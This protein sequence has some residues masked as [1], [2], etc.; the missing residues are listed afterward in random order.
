MQ[1]PDLLG[2]VG[3]QIDSHGSYPA[4]QIN[5]VGLE[6]RGVSCLTPLNQRSCTRLRKKNSLALLDMDKMVNVREAS[7]RA[8]GFHCT[9]GAVNW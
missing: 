9:V 6:N 8:V 2:G 1:L 3:H 4:L 5:R 7:T